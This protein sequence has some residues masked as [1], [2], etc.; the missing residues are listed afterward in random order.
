M[1]RKY[2]KFARLWFLGL[3]SVILLALFQ[4]C[5]GSFKAQLSESLSELPSDD[6]IASVPTQ[7]ETDFHLDK[8]VC[9]P[10]KITCSIENG[11]GEQVWRDGAYGSCT[12]VSCNEN[13]SLQSNSCVYSPGSCPIENGNGLLQEDRTCRLVNCNSNFH[14]NGNM[15]ASNSRSCVISNGSGTQTWTGTSYG[16]CMVVSCNVG[17]NQSGNSCVVAQAGGQNAWSPRNSSNFF[18]SGHSL[19]DGIGG[20][21][22][23]IAAALGDSSAFNQQ[24]IL[25]SPIRV[26]KRGSSTNQWP[27]Y[28]EGT[29]RSPDGYSSTSGLN[30]ISELLNPQTIG[31]GRRY[32]TLVIAENHSSLLNIQWEDTIGYLRHYHDRLID[33]NQIG[34][35][36]FYDTWLDIN[37]NDPTLWINHE[38]NTLRIWECVTSKVNI[39]LES[40]GRSDRIL[41]MPASTALVDLVERILANQIPGISGT[42]QEKLNQIFSDNVHLTALGSYYMSLVTYSSVFGKSAVGATPPAGINESTATEFQRVAW[43]YISSYYNRSNPGTRTMAECRGEIS[44]QACSTF[45][46]MKGEP[47]NVAGCQNYFSSNSEGPFRDAN[48]TAYPAP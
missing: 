30:V 32:D 39:S 31:S 29:N 45:W 37:K 18:V 22:V 2:T 36:L 34:R 7:C 14:Q 11:L 12:V 13:Y 43:S 47:G 9:K 46:A 24:I 28:S 40:L 4:N 1:E 3:L 41:N 5:S 23:D 21:V 42:N 19:T 17:F 6:D 44:Q 10:D 27:G 33:A 15:C 8:G 38:K 25:G 20:R 26:R 48:F 35:T 16:S